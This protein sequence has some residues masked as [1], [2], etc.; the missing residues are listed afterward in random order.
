MNSY[1]MQNIFQII[2]QAFIINASNL[3]WG[4][5]ILLA[6]W[7]VSVKIR[8]MAIDIFNKIRLNQMA[9][10]LGWETFF[11]RYDAHLNI[12]KFFG[13]IIEALFLIMF[14]TVFFDIIGLNQFNSV[15]MS[16]ISFF[17]NILI[18]MIIFIF[19]IF[20][21][22]F[23]KKIVLVSLEKEKITYSGILGNI[24][25]SAAWILAVLA[26]LYQLNIVPT[27][28]LS[29]FIG[30]VALIVITFG[31]AFGLGGKDLAK[32]LLEGWEEKMK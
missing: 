14:F 16:I 32:K 31:L 18:S 5:F 23:S 17:P 19:A 30:F 7:F 24:I 13:A 1:F 15:L 29:I 20:I 11:D 9:K 28:I 3:I 12:A 4:I 10:T 22:S 21:A 8:N 25:S 2:S 6:G 27:L 26:I